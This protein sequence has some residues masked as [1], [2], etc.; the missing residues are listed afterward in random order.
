M[1]RPAEC[2]ESLPEDQAI[3]L[4]E[5]ARSLNADAFETE[6]VCRRQ[7]QRAIPATMQALDAHIRINV[8]PG[9]KWS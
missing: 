3:A 2:R 8:M 5:Y 7:D 4:A 1:E 9:M 6:R